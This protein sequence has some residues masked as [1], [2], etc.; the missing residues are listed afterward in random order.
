MEIGGARNEDNAAGGPAIVPW[1]ETRML[2]QVKVAINTTKD[3]NKNVDPV[4]IVNLG[5]NF[6][7]RDTGA[8]KLFLNWKTVWSEVGL[9]KGTAADC[10]SIYYDYTYYRE[11]ME[12]ILERIDKR[13]ASPSLSLPFIQSSHIHW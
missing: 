1:N 12:K 7:S 5:K 4:T 10:R 11:D 3:K 8:M 6:F 9:K 13:Y 2:E